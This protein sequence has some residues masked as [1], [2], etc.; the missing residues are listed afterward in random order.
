MKRLLISIL[1]LGVLSTSLFAQMTKE[2]LYE[3]EKYGYAQF[4]GICD[5]E[6]LKKIIFDKKIRNYVYT[7]DKS[8][9]LRPDGTTAFNIA[10]NGNSKKCRDVA[11][12]LSDIGVEDGLVGG[13]PESF[14]EIPNLPKP[15]IFEDSRV[16]IVFN[17]FDREGQPIGK[18]YNKTDDDIQY[19]GQKF[20]LNGKTDD[21]YLKNSPLIFKPNSEN[22]FWLASYD[23]MKHDRA[24]GPKIIKNKLA[25]DVKD[26][27]FTYRYKG[28]EYTMKLKMGGKYVFDVYYTNDSTIFDDEAI[29]KE[30]LG[31]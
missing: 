5:K 20:T 2:E 18:L 30:Q 10:S 26:A 13:G 31:Y 27:E 17:R 15:L 19:V 7:I 29:R 4:A 1:T 12:W 28:K 16:K 14:A 6:N 23:F 9:V 25:F 11:R 22:N 24:S 21:R 3:T 8:A